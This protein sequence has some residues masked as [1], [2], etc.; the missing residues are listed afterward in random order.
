MRTRTGKKRSSVMRAG[1][2]TVEWERVKKHWPRK[3]SELTA[4][5]LCLLSARGKMA[6]VQRLH[7]DTD[8][9]ALSIARETLRGVSGWV[10]P[11]GAGRF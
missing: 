8:R 4:Y 1:E 10:L 3:G 6:A 11:V 7:A 5:R 2:P 9:E